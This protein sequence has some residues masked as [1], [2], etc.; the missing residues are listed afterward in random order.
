MNKKEFCRDLAA[1]INR[2]GIDANFETADDILADVA[3][4][5]LNA[6]YTAKKKQ[7]MRDN[8]ELDTCDCPAC[9]LRRAIAAA[10]D[11]AERMEPGKKEYRKPEAYN[12]PT[13][14]GEIAEMVARTDEGE[15]C[16]NGAGDAIRLPAG[17]PSCGTGGA[18]ALRRGVRHPYDGR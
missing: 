10:K 6:F 11:K 12:I 9:Q 15:T 14:V 16:K 5:A 8:P 1:L 3:I 2:Y 18:G 13:E 4:D 7:E 17:R